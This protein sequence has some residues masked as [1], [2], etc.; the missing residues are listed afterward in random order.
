MPLL[1][2]RVGPGN[3]RSRLAQADPQLPE[4]ALTLPH[5]QADA[6]LPFDPGGQGFAVPQI[7]PPAPAC[8]ASAAGRHGL[9][10]TVS[11]S[12]VAVVRHVRPQAVPPTPL[13][14]IPAPH[15]PRCAV[16]PLTT[17]YLWT[18][19]TLGHQQ[20]TVQPMVIAGFF[21]SPDFVLQ[22]KNHG[23]CVGNS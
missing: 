17:R 22:S 23:G 11:R 2:L 20:H 1:P 3:G 10:A 5:S 18:G 14:Q 8:A 19:H 13:P 15:T 4:Q 7:A 16:H 6:I 12:V 21:G 9:A